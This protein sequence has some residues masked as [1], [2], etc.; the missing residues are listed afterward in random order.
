VLAYPGCPGKEAVKLVQ[1]SG[2]TPG[3]MLV[4]KAIS[5][6][7]SVAQM[8]SCCRANSSKASTKEAAT[9]C[10]KCRKDLAAVLTTTL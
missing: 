2:V 6:A 5:G 7:D 10:L 1:F 4:A 8:P 9:L 3:W